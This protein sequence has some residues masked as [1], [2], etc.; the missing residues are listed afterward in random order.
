MADTRS[1]DH[2]GVTPAVWPGGLSLQ[3]PHRVESFAICPQL[4]AF[5]HDIKLRLAVEKTAT[6][7]GNLVHVGL[8]YRYGAMLPQ[9]PEWLVYPD[10]MTAIAVCG[11]DRPD[12]AYEAARIYAWYADKY[13]VN[14]WVPVLVEHQFIV[15][16]GAEPYSCRTDLLAVESNEYVLIDHK[17]MG[18]LNKNVGKGY[19]ND[20]QMLT[21]LALARAHGYDVRRIVINALTKEYPFPQFE[22]YDVPISEI[23]YERFGRDTEYYLRRMTEVRREFPNPWDRPRN[24]GSCLRKYGPCDYFPI[25]TE[26]PRPDVML[27]YVVK[28][29]H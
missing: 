17:T 13:K 5:G 6:G 12:L 16:I 29:G 3:G 11:Q 8:A 4:E 23:A 9:R 24:T 25:C 10:P 7:I 27:D 19:R 21:G 2:A 20:R 28:R 18:K 14:T 26:G 1:A 15:Q 22:R